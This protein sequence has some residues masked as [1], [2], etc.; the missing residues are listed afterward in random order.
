[1]LTLPA[2]QYK[3]FVIVQI[4]ARYHVTKGGEVMPSGDAINADGFNPEG[5]PTMGHAKGAIT[6]RGNAA[7]DT[8]LTTRHTAPA[9]AAANDDKDR[10]SVAAPASEAAKSEARIVGMVDALST[11]PEGWTGQRNTKGEP[12]HGNPKLAKVY[13]EMDYYGMTKE[14]DSRSRNKREGRYAGRAHGFNVRNPKARQP[15]AEAA[16]IVA[17]ERA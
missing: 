2:T 4:G 12:I 6:K 3:N 5:F 15:S 17:G 9:Q 13:A 10:A 11:T 16:N 8:A 1:M 14:R 7:I